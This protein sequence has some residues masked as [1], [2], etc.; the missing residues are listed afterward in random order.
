VSEEDEAEKV[1]EMLPSSS[2]SVEL[3]IV[4]ALCRTPLII[5]SMSCCSCQ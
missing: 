5:A 2:L 4:L 3:P 1:G